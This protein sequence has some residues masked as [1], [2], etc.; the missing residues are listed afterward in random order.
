MDAWLSTTRKE[1]FYQ[2]VG[3]LTV[4][5]VKFSKGQLKCFV[6]LLFLHCP[7]TSSDLVGSIPFWDAVCNKFTDLARSGDM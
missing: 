5:N 3:I 7:Q 6:R 2:V 1:F 4:G